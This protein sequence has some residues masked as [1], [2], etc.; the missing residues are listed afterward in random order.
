MSQYPLRE[1][2]ANTL[3]A[4]SNRPLH[5]ISAEAVGAGEVSGA[6]LRIHADTL[7]Q[8]ADIARA[9]GFPQLAANLLRAAE[10]SDVPND[11]LLRIYDM[12]RPERASYAELT[13]LADY[14]EATYGACE[15]AA[16]IREAADV[17]RE[18]NLLRR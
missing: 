17:Y 7:R 14:L 5:E 13:R 9:S 12:L 6:D 15:N 4:H 8:Q 2:A 3:R 10:L 11:E 16:F 1:H 18:R